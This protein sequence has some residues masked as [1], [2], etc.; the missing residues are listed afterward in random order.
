MLP[1]KA[2]LA[3]TEPSVYGST[4]QKIAL[5]KLGEAERVLHAERQK[6]VEF[7]RRCD[8][9]RFVLHTRSVTEDYAASGT[10]RSVSS[11]VSEVT[12][13]ARGNDREARRE[14][15]YR[16]RPIADP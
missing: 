9:S 12:K 6:G 16:Q 5:L 2:N 10:A 7:D 3:L 8:A 11:F 4:F 1:E 14:H 13:E 15:R